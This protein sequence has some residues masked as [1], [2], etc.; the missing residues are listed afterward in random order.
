MARF[1]RLT[2]VPSWR[3]LAV[4]AWDKPSDPS[5]YGII[6]LE[7]DRT[8]PY[9]EALR[10]ASG[11]RVSVTH[12]VGK[13]I[14]CAIA[15]R[16][17][18]NA[19]IRRGRIWVRDSV[20]VFFQVAFEGGNDLA[21]AKVSGADA[22][23][24]EAIARDLRE[25]AQRIRA[26]KDDPTQKS[27]RM[28]TSL[29]PLLTR[30]GMRI[31][32]WLSYQVGLDLSRLGIPFDGFGSC[33]VTNVGTFGIECGFAPLVPFAHAPIL[34]LVGEVREMARVRGGQVVPVACLQIGATFDHRL[35]DGYQAG[36]LAK[37][38]RAIFEDPERE[39]GAPALLPRAVADEQPRA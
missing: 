39:L 12:L 28:L 17:E 14:A 5:V 29:H 15:E 10:A 22:L 9:L 2:K 4:H 30:W 7:C 20:D 26:T 11:E 21:G 37:R 32:E 6:T 13:A 34:L 36:L 24:V 38:F 1:R 23:S 16:P 33:M 25:R 35:L 8:L 27:T 19:I 18:V 31:G 3:A